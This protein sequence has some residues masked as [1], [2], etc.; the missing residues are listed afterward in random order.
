MKP[1]C[2]LL[3][4]PGPLLLQFEW[5][6]LSKI[7]QI[8]KVYYHLISFSLTPKVLAIS[9]I[10]TQCMSLQCIYMTD[11]VSA[12]HWASVLIHFEVCMGPGASINYVVGFFNLLIIT[13]FAYLSTGSK[14]EKSSLRFYKYQ[15]HRK[16][17]G[18]NYRVP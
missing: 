14:Q 12:L 5:D 11:N 15:Q 6:K 17:T 7:Y 18:H 13:S 2:T 1:I 8:V 9:F 10:F 3:S 4:V 16:S